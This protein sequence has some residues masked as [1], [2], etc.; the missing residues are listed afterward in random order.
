MENE[1]PLL[2]TVVYREPEGRAEERTGSTE[3]E[4]LTWS[5]EG[6]NQYLR[7]LHLQA[8]RDPRRDGVLE[9]LSL[10]IAVGLLFILMNLIA[11]L[12]PFRLQA[13]AIWMVFLLGLICVLLCGIVL[14]KVIYTIPRDRRIRPVVY[15]Y[16]K[17]H[18]HL[19]PALRSLDDN[20]APW[21][22]K[23]LSS[24]S[25]ETEGKNSVH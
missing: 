9:H 24:Y 1:N 8:L 6:F 19:L 10:F 25:K 13:E 14:P 15:R 22:E 4:F 3:H 20:L 18:P 21:L 7:L 23:Y 11:S 12:A 5:E 16:V 2:K 17:N